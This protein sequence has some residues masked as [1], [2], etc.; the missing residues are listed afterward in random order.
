M[1]NLID[2]RTPTY[3][4]SDGRY[5][6]LNYIVSTDNGSTWQLKNNDGSMRGSGKFMFHK[7]D[8]A[9][10]EGKVLKEKHEVLSLLITNIG[11]RFILTGS[12]MVAVRFK[13]HKI[14]SRDI[15]IIVDCNDTETINYLKG[16][17]CLR[18]NTSDAMAMSSFSVIPFGVTID[19]FMETPDRYKALVNRSTNYSWLILAPMDYYLRN[20][21][22]CN[23]SKFFNHIQSYLELLEK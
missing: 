9:R 23:P 16:L 10:V 1:T 18:E 3:N 2:Y 5:L 6:G 19:V 11:N 14:D 17:G 7:D 13:N 20:K 8:L 22:A 12:A 15:D 4:I 21:F